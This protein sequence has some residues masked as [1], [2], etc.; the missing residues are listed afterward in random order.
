MVFARRC[1]PSWMTR[2]LS[3]DLGLSAGVVFHPEVLE[4]YDERQ[5]LHQVAGAQVDEGSARGA[6]FGYG[7]AGAERGV[8]DR[9]LALVRYPADG[10]VPGFRL[11][12]PAQGLDFQGNVT[13]QESADTDDY[14]GA[15]W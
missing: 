6:A 5:G 13:V 10:Q 14:H 8:V 9:Q 1:S 11:Q 4:Q 7:N 12:L 15:V 3:K 2:S